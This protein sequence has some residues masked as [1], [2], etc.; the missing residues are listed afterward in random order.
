MVE[1]NGIIF[2]RKVFVTGGSLAIIIPPELLSYLQLEEAEAI[3]ISGYE[4][5]KGKYIALWKK[6]GR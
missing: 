5:K 3:E 4:G 2:K 1:K 6:K